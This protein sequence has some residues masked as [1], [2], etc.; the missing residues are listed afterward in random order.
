MF[1]FPQDVHLVWF[2]PFSGWHLEKLQLWRKI[3]P[4]YQAHLWHDT[5]TNID[6][7]KQENMAVFDFCRAAK[8]LTHDISQVEFNGITNIEL[9]REE[10]VLK[11]YIAACDVLKVGLMLDCAG[12]YVDF[13]REPINSLQ[14]L[15]SKIPF[16]FAIHRKFGGYNASFDILGAAQPHLG[17]FSSMAA[18]HS[19][20]YEIIH[21]S[22]RSCPKSIH[23][24]RS[25]TYDDLLYAA[26]TSI[27]GNALN[28]MLTE[29]PDEDIAQMAESMVECRTYFAHVGEVASRRYGYQFWEQP[30][31]MAFMDFVR[32]SKFSEK[33]KLLAKSLVETGDPFC[34]LALKQQ[35]AFA[36]RT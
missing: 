19:L 5:T 13:D 7:R 12:L 8:I 30:G 33:Q 18:I 34:I 14:K 21:S 31:P 23:D 3:N 36:P 15:K 4:E 25:T 9:V 16:V 10:I 28:L 29:L 35:T 11:H 2:G 20:S 17:L 24:W 6:P 1:T 26:T 22:Q 32:Q 27:T